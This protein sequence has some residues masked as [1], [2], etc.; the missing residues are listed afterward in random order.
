MGLIVAS[1]V[2]AGCAGGTPATF[3]PVTN[4]PETSG[5]TATIAPTVAATAD[6]PTDPPPTP[7]PLIVPIEATFEPVGVAP[8]GAI[9]VAM[10]LDPGPVFAPT[11]ITASGGIIKLFLTNPDARYDAQHNFKIGVAL[12][13]ESAGSPDILPGHSGVL[14]LEDVEAGKYIFWCTV[15]S[16][17]LAGMQGLL[18]VTP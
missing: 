7:T 3:D 8:D 18:T 9:E 1:A 10:K 15:Q 13:A 16:H 11:E 5:P 4:R 2:L 17:Y 6:A 12:R 14:T